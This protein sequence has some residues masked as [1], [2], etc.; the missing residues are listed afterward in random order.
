[1]NGQSLS[2][3]QRPWTLGFAGMQS[4]I[5][6]LLERQENNERHDQSN[7]RDGVS[8]DVDVDHCPTKLRKVGM[9]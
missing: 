2:E 1:M 3:L 6:N 4:R 7:N 5:R 8:D 9:N